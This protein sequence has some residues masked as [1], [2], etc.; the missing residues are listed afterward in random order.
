[1]KLSKLDLMIYIYSGKLTNIAYYM[2]TLIIIIPI[3]T[4]LVTD[5]PVNSFFSKI[6][7]GI[8]GL[9]IIIGKLLV[10]INKKKE[11]KNISIDMGILTGIILAL[12]NYI[13][14]SN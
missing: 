6:L 3:C 11:N 2:A 10:V 5:T 8:S 9:F 4:V 13:L 1:M 7:I 12:I 14:I